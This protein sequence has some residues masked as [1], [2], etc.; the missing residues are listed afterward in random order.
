MRLNLISFGLL[1]MCEQPCNQ[2][3]LWSKASLLSVR[4]AKHHS[5]KSR[6]ELL[7]CRLR[8]INRFVDGL[9]QDINYGIHNQLGNYGIEL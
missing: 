9:V 8:Y 6:L 1:Q 4:L 5:R 7:K 2:P 3:S